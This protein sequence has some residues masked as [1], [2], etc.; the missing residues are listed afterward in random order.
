VRSVL[1]VD[2]SLTVRMDLDE[3]FREARFETALCATIAAA[4]EALS[5]TAF[6]LIVLDV[7]LPDGD[8]IALLG[9]IKRSPTAASTPVMLLSTEA[10]VRD[11]I[12]GLNTG[13]DEYVGKPYDTAY[14]VS[15]ARQLASA[16]RLS[17]AATQKTVLIIDDSVTFRE[18]LKPALADAGYFV[19]EASSGEEGLRKASAVLPH[20]LIVDGTL[21]GIDGPTVIRRVR[22]DGRLQKT[23]CML[24]TG[25]EAANGEVNALDSGADIYVRKES[26]MAGILARLAALLRRASVPGDESGGGQGPQKILAVDDSVTYLNAL[27]AAMR[28][29]GYDVVMSHS[30]SEALE[31]LAVQPVDCILLDLIMPGLSGQET[32]K[33]IKSSPALRNV[34]LIMLTSLDESQAMIAGINSGADD[35]ITK[36]GEFEIVKARVRAQLRRRHFEDENRRIREQLL[37]SEMEA[38]EA[39]AARELAQTR[40]KLLQELKHKNHELESFSYSVS[41]DLRAPLRAIDGFAAILLNDYAKVLDDEGKSHLKRICDAKEKMAVL[42]DALLELSRV[43]RLEMQQGQIDLS[44]MAE[45]IM[46]DFQHADRARKVK[47]NIEKN[48]MATGDA[49]LLRVV[50]TNLLNNAWKYTANA[51]APQIEFLTT[52]HE[53]GLAYVIRDNGAG[54]DMRYA[55]KLFGAFQ[56]L[57]SDHE[58]KGTGIG[59]ATVQ[60]VI[61]RHG[62]NVWAESAPGRGATF[63]FTLPTGRDDS[64]PAPQSTS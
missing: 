6:S 30:G 15:R 18:T 36:S 17:T 32:C 38:A 53:S 51:A 11:R 56:R 50:L 2:D 29:E 10:E 64:S 16:N 55:N 20:A 42:I 21:P 28:D 7:L 12:R 46:A 22:S 4:R 57:H 19:I 61:R 13:A 48:I 58:F 3:A 9:E 34:P 23:P 45:S 24:L 31:L 63:Y 54:F 62:G 35:Y 59:L 60:R 52:P 44:R 1:I 39:R 40:E 26:D 33:R 47:V 37:Q 14:V 8:G 27:S 5:K 41:H 25:S 43:G 49:A